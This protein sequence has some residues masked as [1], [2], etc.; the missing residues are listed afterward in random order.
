MSLPLSSKVSLINKYIQVNNMKDRGKAEH[1]GLLVKNL[2]ESIIE[3]LKVLHEPSD[4][5]PI[6]LNPIIQDL[7][8]LNESQSNPQV[9]LTTL[10]ADLQKFI[11]SQA[12][13]PI[14]LSA[15]IKELEA[16]VKK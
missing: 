4:E 2:L 15:V 3:D 10:A 11:E 9:S 16:S 8:T 1:D 14:Q 6:D 13:P 5:T 7:K 12:N